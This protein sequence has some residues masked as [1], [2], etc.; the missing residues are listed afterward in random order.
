MLLATTGMLRESESAALRYEKKKG[1]FKDV[2]I[3]EVDGE[4]CLFIFIEKSKTDQGRTGEVVVIS[5]SDDPRICPVVWFKYLE[6]IRDEESDFL[7]HHHNSPAGLSSSTPCG[8]VQKWL[9]AI[10]LNG[11]EFGSHSC[12]S[13]GA[14]AAAQAGVKLRLLKR[15]GRWKSDA[16]FLYVRDS[17]I[18]KLEVTR[19]FL[20]NTIA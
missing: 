4:E 15:H 7:Y 10:G 13:G 12:R 9:T 16:V 5:K 6:N 2:W 8:R 20:K 1:G 14:T 3:E 19:G 17:I 18:Q 11:K